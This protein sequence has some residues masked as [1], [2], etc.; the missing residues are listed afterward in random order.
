MPS[1]SIQVLAAYTQKPA[2]GGPSPDLVYA[3]KAAAGAFYI[4]PVGGGEVGATDG[5]LVAILF[6]GASTV[7]AVYLTDKF[8][9]ATAGGYRLEAA[10][11]GTAMEYKSL[12]RIN[13]SPGNFLYGPKVTLYPEDF[14]LVHLLIYQFSGTQYRTWLDR[15]EP[16]APT[17]ATTYAPQSAPLMAQ[18]LGVGKASSGPAINHNIVAMLTA[19][20][21]HTPQQID[22]L[23]L[24]AR[25]K[26]DLPTPGEWAYGITHR[27]SVRDTLGSNIVEG[28]VAPASIADTV[29]GAP[30]DLMART[31]SPKLTILPQAQKW[32]YEAGPVIAGGRGWSNANYYQ[33][34]PA[35][36][37][38][39][40]SGFWVGLLAF[41]PSGQTSKTRQL[42]ACRHLG[43]GW[44]LYAWGNLTNLRFRMYDKSATPAAVE[45]IK[46]LDYDRLHLFVG[47]WTGT[48][49]LGYWKRAP[50]AAAT[51]RNG[52]TPSASE[53]LTV[54]VCL[55]EPTQGADTAQIYGVAYGLGVP[56]Q[57]EVE[58]L[59]DDVKA[60]D[61]MVSIPGKTDHVYRFDG[62]PDT[63]LDQQGSAPLTRIGAPVPVSMTRRLWGW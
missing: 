44:D 54:G 30:T 17:A 8:D 42:V 39:A 19:R 60:A 3:F 21:A 38:G 50:I 58:K 40:E 9:V 18:T 4:T 11:A 61:M 51:A 47:V 32:G 62:L 27:W 26:K 52:F 41:Y 16:T 13:F 49:Q 31:G 24:A 45:I 20:G 6:Q 63:V 56:T 55:A 33:A 28:Q 46:T 25:A 12:S 23:F 36:A 37:R 5:F 59:Y 1:P 57:A 48:A 7:G 15:E 14:A 35:V 10:V 43:G 22:E 34:G 29:T 53:T 2:A